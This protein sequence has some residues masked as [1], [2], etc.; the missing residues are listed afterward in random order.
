MSGVLVI[1]DDRALCRLFE[2]M[3]KRDGLTADVVER[4]DDGADAIERQGDG[5]DAILLDMMLPGMNGAEILSRV[6]STKP[7]LL[8]RILVISAAP[9]HV[10][11]AVE[12]VGDVRGV[13][14][15]PFDLDTVVTTLRECVRDSEAARG[16]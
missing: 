15:K 13:F 11:Q 3:L 16:H 5:Y 2:L 1:E 10:L 9:T 12:K 4:G 14:R 7:Y 6:R 8:D